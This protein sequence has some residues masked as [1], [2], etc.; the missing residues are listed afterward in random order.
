[1]AVLAD[2]LAR[3]AQTA[4]DGASVEDHLPQNPM[5][6]SA[7]SEQP[8][9]EPKAATMTVA[10]HQ[11]IPVTQQRKRSNTPAAHCCIFLKKWA[12]VQP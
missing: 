4:Q 1:V 6:P 8:V 9:D 7:S 3:V 11:H 12:E 2:S 5:M 10:S